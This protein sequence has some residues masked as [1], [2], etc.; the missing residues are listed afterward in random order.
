[1]TP[2]FLK[3]LEHILNERHNKILLETQSRLQK[4]F[5]SGS[6][7]MGAALILSECINE[8]KDRR[9]QLY[10]ATLDV[11][12][13]FDVVNHELLLRKLYLDGIRGNDWLLVQDLY[14]DMTSAVKW[15]GHLSSP[16]SKRQGVRQGGGG[17]VVDPL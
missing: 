8:A 16:F 10:V 11:Q 2:V 3:L 7:S 12:K 4:G 5:T 13:A 6:S 9:D 14:S 15:G 17:V 1:M